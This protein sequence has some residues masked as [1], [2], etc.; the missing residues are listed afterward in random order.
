MTQ[1]EPLRIALVGVGEVARHGHVPTVRARQDV[2]LV[3]TVSHAGRVDGV[4]AFESLGDALAGVP[5]IQAVILCTPPRC[6][7]PLAREAIL[8]RRHVFLE[9]PP[10]IALSEV[11]ILSRLAGERG[12]TLF[13]GWHSQCTPG[14]ET[15]RRW[16]A[17]KTIESVRLDWREDVRRWHPGQDWMFE[18]G[19]MGVF[20]M[21]INALS[22]ATH[23]LPRPFA[24]ID[25]VIEV[26][27]NRQAPIA[28]T[29]NFAD[30]EGVP[31][32]ANFDNRHQGR[33]VW[34]IDVRTAEGLLELPDRGFRLVI[35]GVEQPLDVTDENLTLATE[36]VGLYDRFLDLIAAGEQHVDSTPL[37]HVADAFMLAE[38]REGESFYW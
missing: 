24:L 30:S 21:G 25:A 32:A 7:Y 38:R 15:A 4:P 13:T 23:I 36:Y 12:V 35:D 27:A 5:G 11:E 9:K 22:I 29:L 33:D 34:E 28:A 8:A 2:E 17:G 14:I 1:T 31:L 19:G 6:R 20:D 18:K 16:L 3:A 26:P 10:A 37:V